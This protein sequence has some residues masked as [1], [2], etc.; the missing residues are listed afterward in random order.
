[1]A[2]PLNQ[3]LTLQTLL[4]NNEGVSLI[5]SENYTEAMERLT[6][7][8]EFARVLVDHVS[9]PQPQPME[10]DPS[11]GTSESIPDK[12]FHANPTQERQSQS[13]L[14]DFIQTPQH[15]HKHSMSPTAENVPSDVDWNPFLPCSL[16]SECCKHSCSYDSKTPSCGYIFKDAIEIP[17]HVVAKSIPAGRL[18]SKVSIAVLFNLALAVQLNAMKTRD[19]C[20]LLRA[21]RLYEYAFEMHLDASCEA[22]IV[23][24]LALL[25]NL[26]MVYGQVREYERSHHCFQTMLSTMMLLVES[27]ESRA[28]RQWDGLL[29]NVADFILTKTV[30]APAA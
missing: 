18:C 21:Q 3:T 22:T 7:A 29:S 17:L 16:P 5:S 9:P 14:D 30:G 4:L 15:N 11:V 26:G 20:Q 12:S 13:V 2:T 28:I 24:S 1:M 6:Q 19:A 8:L 25:N 23:Y 27:E 10:E